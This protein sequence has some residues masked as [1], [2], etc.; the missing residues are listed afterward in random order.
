MM[1]SNRLARTSIGCN[2]IL[3][4]SLREEEY[5]FYF[6]ISMQ[7]LVCL[8]LRATCLMWTHEFNMVAMIDTP[9]YANITVRVAQ[10]R[11]RMQQVPFKFNLSRHLIRYDVIHI[12]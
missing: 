7:L 5:I 9:S 4:K 8:E 10:C 2:L 3:T 6:T 1:R 12:L 11:V